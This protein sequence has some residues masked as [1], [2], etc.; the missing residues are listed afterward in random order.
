MKKL[1]YGSSAL[2][3]AGLLSGGAVAQEGITGS[4]GGWWTAQ[5]AT[6]DQDDSTGGSVPNNRDHT[7]NRFGT[8]TFSGNTTLDNGL[9]AGV[10]FDWNTETT[11]AEVARDGFVWMEFADFRLELGSRQGAPNLMAYTAP[12]PSMWAWGFNSPVFTNAVTPGDNAAGG[13]SQVISFDGG[14]EKLTLFTPRFGGFQV[15]A[16]Y[17]PEGGKQH[18]G[19]DDE[20][21][22]VDGNSS[23]GAPGADNA[24][25]EQSEVF[26]IGANFVQSLGEADV[27]V[28]AGWAEGTLEAD[29]DDDDTVERDD[30]AEWSVGT[31]VVWMSWT[32][33]AAY[34]HSNQGTNPA[35]TDRTDW[36]AG[37]RYAM[38]PWGVGVQYQETETELGAGMGADGAKRLE[39]GGQYEIGPGISFQLGVQYTDYESASADATTKAANENESTAIYLGTSIFF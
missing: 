20:D 14:S 2:V 10:S 33:G 30:Q 9:Q 5:L 15:G 24:V 8:I 1:L 35:N 23:F 7:F 39:V 31:S 19:G 11:G 21:P 17:T 13:P 3:A 29:D 18:V 38:G 28:S 26:Q 12:A 6:V 22:E 4:V 36:N 25:G 27:S 32:F 16:S 34:K 37:V